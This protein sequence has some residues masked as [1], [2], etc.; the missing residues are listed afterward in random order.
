MLDFYKRLEEQAD[1]MREHIGEMTRE[2]AILGRVGH[3]MDGDYLQMIILNSIP[4][5]TKASSRAGNSLIF[6]SKQLQFYT[7]EFWR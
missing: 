1:S 7:Q 2:K 4:E 3:T 5:N 6:L